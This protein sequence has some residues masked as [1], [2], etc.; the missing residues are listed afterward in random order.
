MNNKLLFIRLSSFLYFT[1]TTFIYRTVSFLEAEGIPGGECVPLTDTQLKAQGESDPK[2]PKQ[3]NGIDPS[4][5][6]TGPVGPEPKVE[7][8]TK[9][10]EVEDKDDT[11]KG[12]NDPLQNSF[13]AVRLKKRKFSSFSQVK[14]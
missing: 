10:T 13:L 2:N 4:S 1:F 8:T 5:S 14:M 6:K 7:V 11:Q 3:G 9:T 12:A